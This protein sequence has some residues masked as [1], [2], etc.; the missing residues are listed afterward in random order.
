MTVSAP[1]ADPVECQGPGVPYAAGA[2]GEC[3]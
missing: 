1:N 2:T 3:V